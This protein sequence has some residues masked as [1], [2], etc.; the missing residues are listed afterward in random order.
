V[1]P[2]WRAAWSALAGRQPRCAR[3][4]AAASVPAVGEAD[5]NALNTAVAL[6]VEA[7]EPHIDLDVINDLLSGL[8]HAKQAEVSAALAIL[9]STLGRGWAEH[10]AD[11]P[12]GT[13]RCIALVAAGSKASP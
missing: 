9:A 4:D 3:C 7:S 8:T 13:L 6:V 10:M 1:T 11:E 5:V 12:A 2:R